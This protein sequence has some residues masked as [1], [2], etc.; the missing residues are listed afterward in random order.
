VNNLADLIFHLSRDS[1]IKSPRIAVDQ[2]TDCLDGQILR[3]ICYER[4]GQW[5]PFRMTLPTGYFTERED[6]LMDRLAQSDFVLLPN[7][8]SAG[9]GYPYDQEMRDLR[10][11]TRAWCRAHLGVLGN[12]PLFGRTWTLYGQPELAPPNG[13]R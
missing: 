9:Q 4:H 8:D 3:V 13:L 10:P 6:V 12:F 5:V 2:I 1:G 11:K 7:D